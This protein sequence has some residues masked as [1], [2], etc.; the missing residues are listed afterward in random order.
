MDPITDFVSR[1]KIAK[2]NAIVF[3]V[4]NDTKVTFPPYSGMKVY[5]VIRGKF[6]VEID[7]TEKPIPLN[8]GD[9]FILSGGNPFNIYDNSNIQPTDVTKIRLREGRTSYFTNG[10]SDFSFVGCRFSFKSNDPLRML[11]NLPDPLV[12]R[13]QDEE[14]H[15]LEVFLSHLS[16]EIVSPT[17]GT[18]L[19]TESLLRI[20]LIKSLRSVIKSMQLDI[21][22]CWLYALAD[23][24]IGPVLNNIHENIGRKWRINELA[25]IAGMSRSNFTSKF[26]ILTGFSVVE[27]IRRWRFSLAIEKVI[28]NNDKIS[29]VAL[30]LGYESLSAFSSAFKKTMGHSPRNYIEKIAKK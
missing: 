23:N 9:I 28:S 27:Y 22:S 12:V 11:N 17:Q 7:G 18:E 29:R 6:F 30:D 4:K 10:A 20:I 13:K 16:S 19:I 5:L 15:G 2:H 8:A 24:N 3:D 25:S 26:K 1:L 21:E 14:D